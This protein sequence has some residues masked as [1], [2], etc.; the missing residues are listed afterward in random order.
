MRP[1]ALSVRAATLPLTL[2]GGTGVY[3]LSH[4]LG[5]GSVSVT[6]IYLRF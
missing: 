2:R 1:R 6:E 5:H 3:A 4:H